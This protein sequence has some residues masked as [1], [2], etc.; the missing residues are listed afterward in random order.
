MALTL[1]I[2]AVLAA[3]LLWRYSVAS[4]AL[5]AIKEEAANLGV[6]F[7]ALRTEKE[8]N[9]ATNAHAISDLRQQLATATADRDSLSKFVDIRDTVVE[10][11]RIRSE[12][13]QIL[14]FAENTSA[15]SVA[16]AEEA[17]TRLVAEAT[18]EAKQRRGEAE[19]MISRAS[20]Q[21]A[22][23]IDDARARAEEIGGMLSVRWR[24]PS[25]WQRLWRP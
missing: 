7:E 25:A 23:V 9:D 22:K 24:T 8:E 18:A 20:L 14:R 5:S 21:A 6:R 4:Q 12:A 17:A 3:V 1:I 13:A 10:A 16:A 11:D 19:Q 2:L 15:A